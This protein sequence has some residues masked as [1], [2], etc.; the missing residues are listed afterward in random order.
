MRDLF[1]GVD[2]SSKFIDLAAITADG[3][4]WCFARVAVPMQPK[5]LAGRGIGLAM[6]EQ[7]GEILDRAACCW[8]ERGMFGS[9]QTTDVLAAIRGAILDGLPSECVADTVRP[10]SWRAGLGM[11]GGMKRDDAKAEARKFASGVIDGDINE[12]T[13]DQCEAACIAWL[14]WKQSSEV[15]GG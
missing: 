7:A 8:V 9:M 4:A 2:Y 5:G 15:K 14:A 13:D 11:R 3:E 1:V 12:L 6:R 10:S